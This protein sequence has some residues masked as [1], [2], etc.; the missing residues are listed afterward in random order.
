MRRSLQ[1]LVAGRMKFTEDFEQISRLISVCQFDSIPAIGLVTHLFPRKFLAYCGAKT[2]FTVRVFR[3]DFADQLIKFKAE[4][5]SHK[6]TSSYI[7]DAAD[8]DGAAVVR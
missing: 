8:R 1:A 4:P 7:V 6:L 5:H 3:S 2:N